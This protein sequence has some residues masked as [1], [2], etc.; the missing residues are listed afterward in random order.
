MGAPNVIPDGMEN[1]LSYAVVTYLKR[2][3]QQSKVEADRMAATIAKKQKPSDAGVM[4][5]P[6]YVTPPSVGGGPFDSIL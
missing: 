1:C 6:R 3:K 2:L 5:A 4:V